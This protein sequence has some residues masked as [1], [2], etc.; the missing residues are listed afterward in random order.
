MASFLKWALASICVTSLPLS[1]FEWEKLSLLPT[2][3]NLSFVLNSEGVFV[4]AGG[5]DL[6]YSQDSGDNWKT[7][8]ESATATFTGLTYGNGR[9]IATMN[10]GS[11]LVSDDGKLW[12]TNIVASTPVSSIIFANGLFV[13]GTSTGV[14]MTST[15]GETWTSYPGIAAGDLN[16]AVHGNGRFLLVEG[17]AQTN[18]IYGVTST[19]GVGWT[20]IVLTGIPTAVCEPVFGCHNLLG[21]SE[22]T[23]GAGK[24]A[25]GVA[26]GQFN[27]PSRNYVI[28]TDAQNWTEGP[29]WGLGIAFEDGTFYSFSSL[30][31]IWTS[32]D[33]TNRVAH[34]IPAPATAISTGD[35]ATVAVG[36]LATIMTGSS[37]D[38]LRR[39]DN[40][41]KG[42]DNVW[43]LTVAGQTVVLVGSRNSSTG[44][45][46]DA[47]ILTS[48]NGGKDFIRAQL[49]AGAPKY[50]FTDVEFGNG[51]YVA[52]GP[53]IY[54]SVDGLT[55]APSS[56]PSSAVK[57]DI[58]YANRVWRAVGGADIL[59]STNGVDFEIYNTGSTTIYLHGI[60]G[61]DG[62]WIA[63]GTSGAFYRWTGNTWSLSGTDEG[64]D[65]YAIAYGD[66]KFVAVGENGRVYQSPDGLAW[67]SKRII[68]ARALTSVTFASGYFVAIEENTK[69]SYFSN[70]GGLTWTTA[71]LPYPDPLATFW[72]VSSD[73]STVYSA[74]LT[75]TL[76]HVVYKA[77]LAAD[78]ILSGAMTA[79]RHFRLGITAPADG[80]YHIYSSTDAAAA[81]WTSRG[82]VN[83]TAGANEWIDPNPI[84]DR[85]FYQTR[86]EP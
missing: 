40:A 10:N 16:L 62:K 39:V 9:F 3:A 13:V 46:N 19:D 81:N 77:K 30:P 52:I 37:L 4:A 23:F 72:A 14:I 58:A 82:T 15:N 54:N 6:I 42:L 85:M 36:P 32:S 5:P 29:T 25:A 83:L 24:F 43:G 74:G 27:F 57:K 59:T 61:G 49:P 65:L 45:N 48:T 55:W 35:A 84:A 71:L 12:K 22:L 21:M 17:A 44:A 41:E 20:R 50:P 33:L 34:S 60:A 79:D 75:R 78:L 7:V 67:T 73:G 56:N 64:T 26:Y 68:G 47:T 11:A 80:I 31:L 1:G 51:V 53:T 69:R 63:V 28:S 18:R 70:D 66:G 2:D 76:S 38:T 8:T 86:R